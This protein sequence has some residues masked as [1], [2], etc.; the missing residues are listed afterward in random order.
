[1]HNI[2]S[3]IVDMPGIPEFYLEVSK[4]KDFKND[5]QQAHFKKLSLVQMEE[6]GRLEPKFYDIQ[7]FVGELYLK[8]FQYDL[9]D[10]NY[11]K[12]T[13]AEKKNLKENLLELYTWALT[14][15]PKFKSF[16]D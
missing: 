16:S 11:K 15:A 7:N 1:M 6:L 5:F 4:H 9:K 13:E 10:I 14:L 3:E 12:L 2:G 8:K